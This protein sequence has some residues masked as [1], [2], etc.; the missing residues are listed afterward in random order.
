MRSPAYADYLIRLRE[1]IELVRLG[2]KSENA[3]A[4]SACAKG[5]AVLGAAALERYINDAIRQ[6]CQR[7]KTS[8]W[9]ELAEG[10]QQYLTKQMAARLG[11]MS[12]DFPPDASE[13]R[14]GRLKALLDQCIG[15]FQNPATWPHLPE[16][17]MFVE[18]LQEPARINALLRTF[19]PKG[20]NFLD[21][22]TQ[23]GRDKNAL[24]AGLSGLI[25]ARHTAAHALPDGP[26]PSPKDSQAWLVQ[27]FSLAREIDA[28]LAEG[29]PLRT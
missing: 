13:K 4:A 3:V 20:D 16:F 9:E 17:G 14:R 22:L 15:A 27:S 23:R 28:Y 10:Q 25:D 18:G 29:S 12:S 5:A 19:H 21:G 2:L 1:A 11:D 8:K 7:L 6:A 24:T 26:S